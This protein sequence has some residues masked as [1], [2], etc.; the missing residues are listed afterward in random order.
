M[1]RDGEF[2]PPIRLLT[3]YKLGI[4]PMGLTEKLPSNNNTLQNTPLV[5]FSRNSHQLYFIPSSIEVSEV[6]LNL[7][8]PN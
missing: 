1:K 4:N 8:T 6:G 2:Q 7:C 5:L 3:D